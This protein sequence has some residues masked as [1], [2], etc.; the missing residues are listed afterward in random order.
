[1]TRQ[2][3]WTQDPRFSH[4]R[5][6]PAWYHIQ[7]SPFYTPRPSARMEKQ[8]AE[9]RKRE[10]Q[11]QAADGASDAFSNKSCLAAALWPCGIYS[12]TSQRLKAA[13]SGHDAERIPN[14]GCCNPDCVQ[15]AVCLPCKPAFLPPKHNLGRKLTSLIVYGCLL[16]RLQTTVRSFYGIDGTDLSDWYDGC[17]CPCLTIVRNEQEILLREK[18]HKRLKDRHH[19]DLSVNSQY[20]SQNPMAYISSKTSK[21]STADEIAKARTTSHNLNNDSRSNIASHPQVHYLDQH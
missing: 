7:V 4:L 16:S 14:R 15:F 18:Q 2:V 17:C 21:P 13:L 1:M 9:D 5:N 19:H 20:H 6:P 11:W 8:A 12:R 10:W 3:H